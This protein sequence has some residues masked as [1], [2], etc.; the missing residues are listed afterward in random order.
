MAINR[1]FNSDFAL[2]FARFAQIQ[3]YIL[4]KTIDLEN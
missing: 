2:F 3:Y 1:V 4:P